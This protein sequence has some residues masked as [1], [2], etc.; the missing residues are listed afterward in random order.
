MIAFVRA[1]NFNS[2]LMLYKIIIVKFIVYK[3]ALYEIN[4]TCVRMCVSTF[5]LKF[6]PILVHDKIHYETK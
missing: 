6:T 4:L 5:C 2:T 1:F 3:R